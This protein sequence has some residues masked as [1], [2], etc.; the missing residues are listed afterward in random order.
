MA[1]GSMAVSGELGGTTNAEDRIVKTYSYLLTSVAAALAMTP[2]VVQAQIAQNGVVVQAPDHG[3]S[4]LLLGIGVAGAL[5]VARRFL[6][7]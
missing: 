2:S 5:L 4:A 1:C 3:S 7:K 6:K